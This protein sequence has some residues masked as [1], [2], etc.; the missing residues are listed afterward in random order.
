MDVMIDEVNYKCKISHHLEKH[1]KDPLDEVPAIEESYLDTPQFPPHLMHLPESVP[2]SNSLPLNLN[3]NIMSASTMP[4]KHNISSNSSVSSGMTT[5][6]SSLTDGSN[7][8][9]FEI[10]KMNR[11]NHGVPSSIS[12]PMTTPRNISMQSMPQQLGAMGRQQSVNYGGN[13]MV[14]DSRMSGYGAQQQYVVNSIE[15]RLMNGSKASPYYQ[16]QPMNRHQNYGGSMNTMNGF[17]NGSSQQVGG[18]SYLQGSSTPMYQ[19]QQ[20]QMQGMKY[21]NYNQGL[22]SSMQQQ[23]L[24]PQLGLGGMG[25]NNGMGGGNYYNNS[26][27]SN[28][29]NSAHDLVDGFNKLDLGNYSI[30]PQGMDSLSDNF[31]LGGHGQPSNFN[32]RDFS[33]FPGNLPPPPKSSPIMSVSPAASATVGSNS[34]F[35]QTLGSAFSLSTGLSV[36]Q[37][38]LNT[39]SSLGSFT[40]ESSGQLSP[41]QDYENNDLFADHPPTLDLPSSVEQVLTSVE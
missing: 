25:L 37:N 28:S 2:L 27:M 9:F 40:G 24:Q 34:V 11:S 1:L 3:R 10:N 23:R 41:H 6:M 15:S 33:S 22:H 21:G 30:I 26:S 7:D 13:S 5:L 31:S 18:Q 8:P 17:S 20:S 29:L 19:H 4:P 39:T 36:V 16:H 12:G 32:S 14:M 38:G 35:D